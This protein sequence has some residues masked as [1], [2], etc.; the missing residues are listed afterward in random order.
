MVN[1]EDI[2]SQITAYE[3]TSI[4]VNGKKVYIELYYQG[5][6][7]SSFRIKDNYFGN[8]LYRGETSEDLENYLKSL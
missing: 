6:S 7:L 3:N 1:M 2:W 8:I 4:E 5:M